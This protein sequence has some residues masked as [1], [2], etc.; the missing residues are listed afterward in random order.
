MTPHKVQCYN[1]NG[2]PYGRYV[3]TH[4]GAG[5]PYFSKKE[6][7]CIY[8]EYSKLQDF[9][10]TNK[11]PFPSGTIGKTYERDEVEIEY[12]MKENGV[13]Y[14]MGFGEK[15]RRR[16]PEREWKQIF[17]LIPQAIRD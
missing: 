14:K 13:W 5:R 8:D 11:F 12:Q 17:R 15:P 10:E 4:P 1:N 16:M 6:A 3:V 9:V 7:K 2:E